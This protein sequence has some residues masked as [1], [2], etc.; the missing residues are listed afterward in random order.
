MFEYEGQELSVEDIKVIADKAGMSYENTLKALTSKGMVESSDYALRPMTNQELS[1]FN[2]NPMEAFELEESEIA[3]EDLPSFTQIKN[4]FSN[5]IPKA[6]NRFETVRVALADPIHRLFGDEA[7]ANYLQG[8]NLDKSIPYIYDQ[9]KFALGDYT[10]KSYIDPATKE[11]VKFDK[12]AYDS[13]GEDAEEN[14]RYFELLNLDKKEDIVE[15]DT[16]TN[17]VIGSR[18]YSDEYQ[19]QNKELDEKVKSFKPITDPG[20]TGFTDAM[21]KGQ[22]D[23]MVA[24][25]ISFIGDM[26]GQSAEYIATRGISTA[27]TMFGQSYKTFNDQKSIALYGENDPDRVKKLV[28]NN[29]EEIL[30][31]TVLGSLGFALEKIGME[32]V[33]SGLF[34]NAATM[35]I[36]ATLIKASATEGGTEYLQGLIEKFNS[37]L[38]QQ[39]TV[40]QAS[41]DV[42]NYATSEEAFDQLFAGLIGGGGMV[43]VSA[44]LNAALRADETS[45]QFVNKQVNNG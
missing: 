36:P 2:R 1:A 43:G 32:Q 17:S 26:A 25:S 27:A 33:V 22:L 44:G 39:K 13:K 4:A 19:A 29:Q 37:S 28:E 6:I 14:K 24:T 40:Q 41:M 35:S 21:K 34:K 38:G 12:E 23:D 42:V 11:L 45:N 7:A 20:I 9:F 16:R 15:I 3:K 30:I 5:I 18:K 31:P 8:T 10:T